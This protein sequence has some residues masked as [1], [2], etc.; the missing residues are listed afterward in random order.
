MAACA[1]P[2]PLTAG[3]AGEG[4]TWVR[5]LPPEFRTVT[6]TAKVCPRVM[7]AGACTEVRVSAEGATTSAGLESTTGELTAA[8][9][10]W[11]P[12]T[13]AESTKVPVPTGV[14][15][16]VKGTD[17]PPAMSTAAGVPLAVAPTLPVADA[18]EGWSGLGCTAC[19]TLVPVLR[20]TRVPLKGTPLGTRAG[21]VS[22]ASSRAGVSS[23]IGRALTVAALTGLP[24]RASAPVAAP[25]KVSA[26]GVSGR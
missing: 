6:A 3:E 11:V 18:T 5:V 7:L 13:P 21:I 2:T 16:Q 26:P 22:V 10:S 9:P 4:R 17:A 15:A 19:A 1:L 14:T 20:T 25:E 23:V 8:P 24:L 12:F